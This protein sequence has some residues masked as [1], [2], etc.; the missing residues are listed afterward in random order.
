MGARAGAEAAGGYILQMADDNQVSRGVTEHK[1]AQTRHQ[2]ALDSSP[3]RVLYWP[4]RSVD[5]AGEPG[6]AGSTQTFELGM[7]A[8]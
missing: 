7:R 6:P 5:G 3:R 1:P 4:V 2:I 8:D